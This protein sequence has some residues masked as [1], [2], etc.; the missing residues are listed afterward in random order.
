MNLNNL[1][2]KGGKRILLLRCAMMIQLVQRQASLNQAAR[3]R[4]SDELIVGSAGKRVGF[5]SL[6]DSFRLVIL[7]LMP[8][9]DVQMPEGQSVRMA[10]FVW[11]EATGGSG[12]LLN[13]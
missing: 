4:C 5:D 9:N 13:E 1:L 3:D 11:L 12:M 10:G 7:C 6:Q 8:C 2:K